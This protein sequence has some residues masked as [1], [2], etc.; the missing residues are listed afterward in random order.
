[1]QTITLNAGVTMP[2]VGF[3]VFQIK[4]AIECTR[5]APFAGCGA[6]TDI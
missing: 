5:W 4:D 2:I 6:S 3:G 1:M